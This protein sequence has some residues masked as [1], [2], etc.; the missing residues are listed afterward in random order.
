MTDEIKFLVLLSAGLTVLM[1]GSYLIGSRAERRTN[2]VP[3]EL[4]QNPFEKIELKAKAVYVYDVRTGEV[5]YAK[6]ENLRL[7]LASLT[8]VMS[9]LV[10]REL[11][12][13]YAE[14]AI[15]G[16]ALAAEG[17]SGLK[18]GEKWNLGD[19]LD[20]SLISSSNDGIRAAALSLGAM[21]KSE[22]SEDEIIGDFV[23]RMNEKAAAL[24]LRNTYFKNETGLDETE[25]KG[26]AYGTAR[27][28]TALME[29]LLIHHPDYLEATR[30]ISAVFSSLDKQ[31]HK[32]TN[33]N[34]LAGDIP[35][36]LAS[37]TGFT[38]TAG[39]NLSLIFD[40]ELGRPVIVTVL[41]S[42]EKGRFEDAAMLIDAVFK[43]LNQN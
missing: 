25:F 17:D 23:M 33:T 11:S 27:D 36:L 18:P 22:A 19:L 26:G 15:D 7:P 12:P 9:A 16:R 2:S 21:S 8:K 29:Y 5:L 43:S 42:T 1:L 20:F 31:S 37:K 41:G 32:A 24:D 38:A 35:G 39:G 13:D 28:V 6:N 10:A 34:A 4:V 14:V 40:P 3:T 30:E